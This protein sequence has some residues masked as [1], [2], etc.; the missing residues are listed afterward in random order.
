MSCVTEVCITR[1]EKFQKWAPPRHNGRL[2]SSREAEIL[3]FLVEGLTNKEIAARIFLSPE[4]V[5]TYVT[6]IL[7]KLGA[8]NRTEAVVRALGIKLGEAP[9]AEDTA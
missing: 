1:A 4:T 3:G 7:K 6:R 5:K 8:R 9:P 2:L